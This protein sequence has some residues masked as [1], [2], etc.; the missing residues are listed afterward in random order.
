MQSSNELVLVGRI[1]APYGVRGWVKVHSFTEEPLDLFNLGS[2]NVTYGNN[3]QF[4]AEIIEYK[5]HQSSFV[6]KLATIDDRDEV[7][8]LTNGDIYISRA[9]L[10][11]LDEDQFYWRDLYG[12][13]VVNQANELLGIL[14]D[15]MNTGANDIMIVQN[16]TTK[17]LIPYVEDMYVKKIDLVERKIIVDWSAED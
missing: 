8:K 11:D 15:S 3:K 14:M 16:G 6:V 13:Q 12:M 4:L 7:A 17:I 1:G 5:P 10:P 2:W 9:D